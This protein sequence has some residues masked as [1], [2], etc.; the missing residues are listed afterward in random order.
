MFMALRLQDC[1]SGEHSL[2]ISSCS[3]RY[4]SCRGCVD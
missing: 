1:I 2:A 4:W 3:G